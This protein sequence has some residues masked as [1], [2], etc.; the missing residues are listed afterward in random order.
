MK[1]MLS[2]KFV[3]H[4]Y[5]TYGC[6]SL[7]NIKETYQKQSHEINIK[8]SAFIPGTIFVSAILGSHTYYRIHTGFLSHQNLHSQLS[9]EEM[10]FQLTENNHRN[11]LKG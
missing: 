10:Y 5:A 8:P 6:F 1:T 2:A 3:P 9:E 11:N 4:M 7:Q